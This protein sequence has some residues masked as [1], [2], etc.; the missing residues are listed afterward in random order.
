MQTLLDKP[1]D[2]VQPPSKNDLS[3]G[4]ELWQQKIPVSGHQL[5]KN[6]LQKY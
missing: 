5:T 4:Q 3:D 2:G 1:G 6:A